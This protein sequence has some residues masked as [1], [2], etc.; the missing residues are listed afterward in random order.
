M[1]RVETTMCLTVDQ[2]VGREVDLNRLL[3]T[4]KLS[5]ICI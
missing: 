1:G 5:Y 4:S 2:N 3:I